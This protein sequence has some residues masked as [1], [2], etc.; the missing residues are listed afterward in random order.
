MRQPTGREGQEVAMAKQ[1]AAGLV[2]EVAHVE[3]VRRAP[4]TRV[5]VEAVEVAEHERVGGQLVALDARRAHCA[6][7]AD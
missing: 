3:R 7:Q 6:V 2:E 5:A 1:L 4:E